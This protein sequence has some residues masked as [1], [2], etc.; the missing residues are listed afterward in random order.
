MMGGGE[1]RAVDG[2]EE[3]KREGEGRRRVE[4]MREVRRRTGG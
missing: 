2:K 3:R 1:G 4:E